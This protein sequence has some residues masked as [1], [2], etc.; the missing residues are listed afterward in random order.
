[1]LNRVLNICLLLLLFLPCLIYNFISKASSDKL[2][3]IPVSL[4]GQIENGKI[5]LPNSNSFSNF[6]SEEISIIK[7]WNKEQRI[8]LRHK[9]KII[10]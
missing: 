9:F 10:S 6:N 1:M 8:K 2:K 7:S 4:N 5:V 3:I